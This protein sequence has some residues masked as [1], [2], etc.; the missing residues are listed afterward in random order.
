MGPQLGRAAVVC[1]C[2]VLCGGSLA[3]L[4]RG[5]CRPVAGKQRVRAEGCFRIVSDS[6]GSAGV[7]SGPTLV[8]GH[9]V[10]L[11]HCFVLLCSRCFSLYFFLE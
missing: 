6:A 4:F 7:V 9:G 11:F 8:V 1:V 10:T 5:G 2:G 3:S